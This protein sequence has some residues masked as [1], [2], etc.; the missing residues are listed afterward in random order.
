MW[1]AEKV[2]NEVQFIEYLTN[3][4]PF[5]SLVCLARV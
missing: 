3:T 4:P 1:R 5:F 2:T